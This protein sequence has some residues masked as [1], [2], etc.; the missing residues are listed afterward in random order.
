MNDWCTRAQGYNKYYLTTTYNIDHQLLHYMAMVT[1]CVSVKYG[2]RIDLA[3]SSNPVTLKLPSW[4]QLNLSGMIDPT[5]LM[6][7]VSP[8][9]AVSAKPPCLKN[10]YYSGYSTKK[11]AQQL[12]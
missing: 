2:R 1:I 8:R 6:A 4:V 5:A 7:I 12:N 10:Y 11:D 3:L 9:Q